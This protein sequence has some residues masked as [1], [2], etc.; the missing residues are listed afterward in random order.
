MFSGVGHPAPAC[1]SAAISWPHTI[2]WK[3]LGGSCQRH[4]LH[5]SGHRYCARRS[6]AKFGLCLAPCDESH[7]LSSDALKRA[8]HHGCFACFMQDNVSTFQ[9]Q[10]I[11]LCCRKTRTGTTG[12]AA[13]FQ[14]Q[15]DDSAYSQTVSGRR[16]SSRNPFAS[17]QPRHTPSLACSPAPQGSQM[18][19]QAP[20]PRPSAATHHC[21]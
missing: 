4:G 15:T 1:G 2:F 13:S 10:A 8:G 21:R 7:C 16:S 20:H 9:S 11:F 14:P 5:C 19:S 3:T 17:S 12:F 6:G 18:E